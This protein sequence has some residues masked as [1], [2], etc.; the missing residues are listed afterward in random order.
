[1]G[2]LLAVLGALVAATA[3][4]GCLWLFIDEAKAPASIIER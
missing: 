3:S 1:M 2:R 4:V